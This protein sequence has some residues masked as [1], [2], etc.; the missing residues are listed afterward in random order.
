MILNEKNLLRLISYGPLLFIP[1][2]VFLVSF[3]LLSI[4]KHQYEQS[5]IDMKKSYMQNQKNQI[6]SKVDTAVKLI[7]YKKVLVEDMVK[8]KVKNRVD[9][10]YSIAHNI[11]LQNIKTHTKTEVQKMIIDSLRPFVWNNGESFIFIL[12]FDGVFHLAPNYLR[13]LEGKS[14]IDFQDATKRYVIREEIATVKSSRE[15]YLWDTFTRPKYDKTTQFKQ[16][17]YV[18]KFDDFNWYMGSAEYID[19]TMIELQDS[20]LKLLKNISLNQEDYYFVIDQK[21]NSIMHGQGSVEDGTNILLLEDTDRKEFIKEF[22]QSANSKEPHFIF[23]KIKNPKTG[24]I[25]EKYSYVEKIPNSNWIVGNGFYLNKLNAQIKAKKSELDA[26]YER[27]YIHILGISLSFMLLSLIA[28]YVISHKLK[29]KLNEYSIS[30]K[31][32]NSELELINDSLETIVDERTIELQQAYSDMKE[33]AI[34]DSLTQAYNR[35]FFNDVLENEIYK[36][37]R[38]NFLFSLSMFDIDNFKQVNDTYGHDIG[39]NVLKSISNITK[40]HLRQSDIFARVGGEEFMILFPN[41]LIEDAAAIAERIRVHIESY[42]FKSVEKV[43]VSIGV[44]ISHPKEGKEELL[45]RVDMALY[46]AK[47]N[48]RNRVIIHI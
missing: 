16:L 32:K 19:T 20:A 27:E 22:I 46:E 17:A 48:G 24:V 40:K 34:K 37:S 25:E 10:A 36:E 4:S 21:G 47:N 26:M 14:I 43:T 28:S 42:N 11:Y 23:Y 15:G 41:T 7:S 3:L 39:D 12:D 33:I 9:T 2:V 18:K 5:I 35:Y 13:G 1:S 44:I 31:E 8:E 30:I 29:I 38:D 45:K 6:I